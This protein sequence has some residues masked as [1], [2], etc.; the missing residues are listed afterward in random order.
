MTFLLHNLEELLPEVQQNCSD[1]EVNCILGVLKIECA[2]HRLMNDPL[3]PIDRK[4]NV[5]TILEQFPFGAMY[6]ALDKAD[7]PSG[8]LWLIIQAFRATADQNELNSVPSISKWLK[9]SNRS[10]TLFHSSR[11]NGFEV[12]DTSLKLLNMRVKRLNS[13][14]NVDYDSEIISLHNDLLQTYDEIIRLIKNPNI[15]EKRLDLLW[16]LLKETA[17]GLG[18]VAGLAEHLDE[19][20]RKYVKDALIEQD[21]I[22]GRFKF[23]AISG[24]FRRFYD[25]AFLTPNRESN[26]EQ[27]LGIPG[28]DSG[29]SIQLIGNQ[30]NPTYLLTSSSTSS[31]SSSSSSEEDD[32]EK[33]CIFRQRSQDKENAEAIKLLKDRGLDLFL[34]KIFYVQKSVLKGDDGYLEVLEYLDEGNLQDIIDNSKDSISYRR[35]ASLNYLLELCVMVDEFTKSGVFF[36]DLKPSNLMIKQ[37]QLIVSDLKSFIPFNTQTRLAPTAVM[38]TKIY[39]PPEQAKHKPGQKDSKD[40][41]VDSYHSYQVGLTIYLFAVGLKDKEGVYQIPPDPDTG[42]RQFNFEHAV[43]QSKRGKELRQVIE[44][45]THPDEN[46]RMKLGDAVSILSKLLG[47]DVLREKIEMRADTGAYEAEPS[48]L[49]TFS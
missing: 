44:G 7:P 31:S 8:K 46:K 3:I 21:E 40:I 37:G 45:L 24:H 5:Q 11:P 15:K 1:S 16:G 48:S 26:L 34:V 32:E 20:K 17:V 33:K 41:N 38:S 14:E 2:F 23:L 36:P 27:L 9:K 25:Q 43:F 22:T 10:A 49:R 6:K 29:C 39:L 12:L 4:K 47:R 19:V 18:Y 30:N 13:E 28:F 42:Q 35:K